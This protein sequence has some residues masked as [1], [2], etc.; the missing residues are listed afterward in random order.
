MIR[1]AG[2]VALHRLGGL[3]VLLRQ[4]E[5]FLSQP[6]VGKITRKPT[7]VLRTQLGFFGIHANASRCGAGNLPARKTLPPGNRFHQK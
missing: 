6:I 5:Q 7:K 2:L 3:I 1:L 4:I